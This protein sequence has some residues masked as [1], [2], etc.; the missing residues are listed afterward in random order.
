[1]IIMMAATFDSRPFAGDNT[2]DNPADMMIVCNII[3]A[4]N[5]NNY[6]MEVIYYWI[7]LKFLVDHGAS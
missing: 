2:D 1:M 6:Q 5:I 3:S 7:K 4:Y